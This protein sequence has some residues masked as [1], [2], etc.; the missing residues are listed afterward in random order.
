IDL[1]SKGLE[2]RPAAKALDRAGIELNFNTVP[3]DQRKPFNPS[4]IR[5]GT[6]ALTTRGLREEHMPMVAAWMDAALSALI[7]DDEGTLDRIAGEVADLLSAFPMPGW[8][9]TP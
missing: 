6:P 5:L 8:A 7:K 4:G 1:T 2:G 3:Y 9:P